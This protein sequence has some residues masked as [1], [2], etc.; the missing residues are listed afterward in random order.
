MQHMSHRNTWWTFPLP[1]QIKNLLCPVHDVEFVYV[2][3]FIVWVWNYLGEFFKR[4][5]QY[6]V[7]ISNSYNT[8]EIRRFVFISRTRS[9]NKYLG[10]LPCC[11][12]WEKP[13]LKS[14]VETTKVMPLG[15]SGT[16]CL[17]KGLRSSKEPLREKC[18]PQPLKTGSLYSQSRIEPL[19][20]Y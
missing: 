14:C 9:E 12:R 18:A 16:Y 10:H 15:M 6:T 3:L 8:W 4:S 7:I 19:L 2:W 1:T 20:I 11:A 17:I 13:D 5:D